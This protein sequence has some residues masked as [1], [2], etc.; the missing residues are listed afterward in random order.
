[1]LLSSTAAV[2]TVA[3]DNVS[4]TIWSLTLSGNTVTNAGSSYIANSPSYYSN[5]YAFPYAMSST[6]AV[7]WL[8][9]YNGSPNYT[10]NTLVPYTINGA[11]ITAGSAYTLG[12][13]FGQYAGP[14]A[15]VVKTGTGVL[16]CAFH[17]ASNSTQKIQ[18]FTLA[19]NVLTA[20]TA[21]T[22]PA[23][24][25]S[26]IGNYA[27]AC[28]SPA[29]NTAIFLNGG[30]S[31]RV[32]NSSNTISS[33]SEAAVS[34]GP[35]SVSVISG[36]QVLISPYTVG[37]G[38]SSGFQGGVGAIGSNNLMSIGKAAMLDSTTGV[39][40]GRYSSSGTNYLAA[41]LLKVI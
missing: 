6:E 14:K 37:Y 33:W 32:T 35:E 28:Y 20:G 34:S 38:N 31:L 22:I 17:N 12:S 3:M 8:G 9:Y 10:Y 23:T 29:A 25:Q 13:E 1:M 16:V 11:T 7:V 41:Q 18:A 4:A 5:L 27:D 2:A 24:N 21:V 19:S 39:A 30:W 26:S 15:R 40:I 36:G